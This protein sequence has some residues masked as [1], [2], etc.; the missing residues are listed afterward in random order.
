M[1][2]IE[3]GKNV[4]SGEEIIG[5][6]IKE[7][8]IGKLIDGRGD[9]EKIKGKKIVKM[10]NIGSKEKG[11]LKRIF[12]ESENNEDGMKIFKKKIDEEKKKDKEEIGI[13]KDIKK[14][15]FKRGIEVELIR[16]RKIV[17]DRLKKV[18]DKEEGIGG[19]IKR[20]GGVNEDKLIDMLIEEIRLGGRKIDIVKKEKDL[21]VVVDGMIEIGKSMRLKEMRRIKKKKR[22]LKWGKRKRELIG[23]VKVEGC[24]DKVK[25]IILEVIWI[26]DEK[27]GMRIDGD[28]EIEI[29]I[30][31]VEEMIINIESVKKEGKLNEEVGKSRFEVVDMGED[32]K[33]ENMVKWCD[34][35]RDLKERKKI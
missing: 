22:K 20:V 21:V 11:E 18:I 32:R 23:E 4:L 2:R 24:V 17:E 7:E 10:K 26:V 5:N 9:E 25:K 31:R 14:N 12:R 6:S 29:D 33:I 19:N 1:R 16:R 15:G 30:N 3:E 8:G 28:E 35:E 13:I 27:K 34:N